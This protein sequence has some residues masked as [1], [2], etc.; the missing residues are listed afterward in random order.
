MVQPRSPALPPGPSVPQVMGWSLP[1]DAA[2]RD[3]T[4][5]RCNERSAATTYEGEAPKLPQPATVMTATRSRQHARQRTYR[6]SNH[7]RICSTTA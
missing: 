5:T 6:S 3:A 1:R 2:T 4:E 7:Q